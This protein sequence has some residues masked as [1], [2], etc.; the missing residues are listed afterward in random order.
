MTRIGWVRSKW[1]RQVGRSGDL[2]SKRNGWDGLVLAVVWSLGFTDNRGFGH[3]GSRSRHLVFQWFR[4]HTYSVLSR[5]VLWSYYQS[6]SSEFRYALRKVL[7]TQ[8]R[9]T[10]RL[11]SYRCVLRLNLIKNNFNTCILT[12]AHTS[13]HLS[14]QHGIFHP[15]TTY[16]FIK[17]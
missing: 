16:L 9:P 2:C 17:Q 4:N 15:K 13:I 12:H 3:K 11:A 5:K 1:V 10:L 14:I 7:G 6:M 8:D